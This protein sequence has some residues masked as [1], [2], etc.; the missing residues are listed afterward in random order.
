MSRFHTHAAASPLLFMKPPVGILFQRV[1]VGNFLPLPSIDAWSLFPRRFCFSSKSE[2]DLFAGIVVVA[3]STRLPDTSLSSLGSSSG[4]VRGPVFQQ[5]D[6]DF[7]CGLPL[8]V[9][10]SAPTFF[11][12]Y[13]LFLPSRSGVFLFLCDSCI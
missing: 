10:P 2:S 9:I 12:L 7:P 11:P 1:P 5:E 8:L 4:P 3:L 13:T 6:I